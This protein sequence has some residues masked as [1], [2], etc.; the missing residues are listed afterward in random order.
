MLNTVRAWILLSTLLCCAGWVLSALHELNRGGYL[1]VFAIAAIAAAWRWRNFKQPSPA[2]IRR[3]WHQFARRFRR[4]AP[5]LFLVLAVMTLA[6]GAL[7]VPVNG[8]SNAY[9]IPRVLHWLGQGQWHWIHTGDERMNSAGCGFEWLTAPLVLF[10]RTDRF[11]F[12]LNWVSYLMVPGLI[13]SI[14]TRFGVRP[15]VA[16]WWMWLFSSGWCFVMQAGSMVNDSLGATFALAAVDLALRAGERK[17]VGDLWLSLLAAAMLTGVKQ[18]S[19]PLVGLWLLAALPGARLLLA[20]PLATAA[21]VAAGLLVS[22]APITFLNLKY[23][24]N[25]MGISQSNVSDPSNPIWAH[26]RSVSPFWGIAGNLFWVPIQNMAPPYLPGAGHWNAAMQKFVQTPFGAHFA[27]FERFG[28]LD[29]YA[30]EGETA[31][32]PSVC[33][34][35]LLSLGWTICRRRGDNIATGTS[36]HNRRLQLLRWTPWVLLLVFMAK[37]S[38]FSVSRLMMPYYAFL[39]PLILAGA[40]HTCLVRRAWWRRL[41]LLVMSSAVLLLVFLQDRP[42]FPAQTALGWMSSRYPQSHFVSRLS[43]LYGVGRVYAGSERNPFAGDLP[44]NEPVVGYAIHGDGGVFEPLLWMPVG[45]RRVERILASDTRE[46][47]DWL[48]IHYV[49][50]EFFPVDFSQETIGQWLERYNGVLV[51]E[52]KYQPR[53]DWGPARLCL[54]RLKSEPG[55]N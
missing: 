25:W 55:K 5:L 32:G 15:R 21:V 41:G 34:L 24:G 31:L 4:L 51:T 11:I 10:T 47:L 48:G 14:F 3:A 20:R 50:V 26:A 2:V 53:A 39:F 29:R 40:K 42:L 17:K 28:I 35:I 22:A 37:V 30:N 19:I 6:G 38:T 46:R 18:T 13:F 49:V 8:D 1:A 54:V 52:I 43:R 9:R 36:Q 27:T 23:T 44:S 45:S 16:W 12:L 7:Y 33:G